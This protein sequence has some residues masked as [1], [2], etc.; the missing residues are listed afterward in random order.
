MSEE[1]SN[2]ISLVSLP[3]LPEFA[4]NAANNLINEPT[5][6]IGHTLGDL[7]FLVFGGISQAADKRRMKYAAD[8]EKYQK[9]LSQK[10]SAIPE[11]D[12]KEPSLQVAAQALENSKYCISEPQLREMFVNLISNSMNN[13]TSNSVHPSFPE[14]IKQMSPLDAELISSFKK[15]SSQP[16]ANFQL[17]YKDGRSLILDSYL[18]F[19]LSRCHSYSYASSISSLERLGLLSVVFDRWF[20]DNSHYEIFSQWSYYQDLKSKHEDPSSGT[21]VEISKG[22]CSLTPLGHAFVNICVS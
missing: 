2:N 20:S 7:W 11:E 18:Y 14:I 4:E 9:E 1:T 6:N 15:A 12:K 22:I 19:D 3:D 10:I 5:Q 13:R 16:I 21:T 8:L 17:K